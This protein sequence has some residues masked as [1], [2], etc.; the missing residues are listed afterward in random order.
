MGRIMRDAVK[1]IGL[2][3]ILGLVGIPALAVDGRDLLPPERAF[4]VAAR[5]PDFAGYG[6]RFSVP[7]FA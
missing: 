5:P 2:L 7:G 4:P 3:L 6:R 1:R